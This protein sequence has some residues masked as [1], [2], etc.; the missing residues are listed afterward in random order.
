MYWLTSDQSGCKQNENVPD[1]CSKLHCAT[2]T[3]NETNIS[4]NE[5]ANLFF[6]GHKTPQDYGHG[7]IIQYS[8]VKWQEWKK[9]F[10]LQTN[11][12]KM[13]ITD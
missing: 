12:A 11:L 7:F 8:I 4:I 9:S 2:I 3:T 10:E 1:C 5:T 13:T 6:L